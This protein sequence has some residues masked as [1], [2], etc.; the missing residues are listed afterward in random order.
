MLKAAAVTHLFEL[1]FTIY[2]INHFVKNY[3]C[4]AVAAEHKTR[5]RPSDDSLA[6]SSVTFYE[7]QLLPD[8]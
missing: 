1:L 8:H 5:A 4:E 2:S 6:R 7:P 3:K